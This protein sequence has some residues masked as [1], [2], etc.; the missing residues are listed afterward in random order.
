M[1]VVVDRERCCGNLQCVA[2]APD[3][4]G[5]DAEGFATVLMPNPL[6]EQHPLIR[7]AASCCPTSAI[8]TTEE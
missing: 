4:F 7:T 5:A 3:V 6:P 8:E 1:K 2:V